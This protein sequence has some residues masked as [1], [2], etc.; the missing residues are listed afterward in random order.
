MTASI[1]KFWP[2]PAAFLQE[3]LNRRSINFQHE[4][5]KHCDWSRVKE[6]GRGFVAASYATRALRNG[7]WVHIG[8]Q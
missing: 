6:V 7:Q 4:S 2:T 3:S 5:G 1:I 8:I